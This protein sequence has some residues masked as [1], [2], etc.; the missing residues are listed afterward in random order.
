[1]IPIEQLTEGIRHVVWDWNGTLIDDID[2][3]IHINEVLF[4]EFGLKPITKEQY[5]AAYCHPISKFYEDL[6]V[7]LTDEQ[8]KV[9]SVR[10][11]ELYYDT[12]DEVKLFAEVEVAL[13]AVR[14]LGLKQSVLTAGHQ[15]DVLEVLNARHLI[16]Y[17]DGVYGLSD[18]YA[19]T[20]L[21]RGRELLV[22]SGVPAEQTLLIG[23]S[24]HDYEVGTSLGMKVILVTGGHESEYRLKQSGDVYLR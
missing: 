23:D 1:M 3:V 9:M 8:F 2:H 18:R 5:R 4:N 16:K 17:F 12:L 13:Q 10:F 6:G 20:K 7:K 14:D 11:H 24:S 19:R 22:D 21:D 15:G